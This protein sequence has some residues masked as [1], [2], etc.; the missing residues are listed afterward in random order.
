MGTHLSLSSHTCS[1]T[2]PAERFSTS[3]PPLLWLFIPPPSVKFQILVKLLQAEPVHSI[4]ETG[5]RARI[6]AVCPWVQ[7]FLSPGRFPSSEMGFPGCP[8]IPAR[9]PAEL[10]RQQDE[11]GQPGHCD[12]SEPH[13]VKGRRPSCDHERYIGQSCIERCP[14]GESENTVP[15]VC[16]LLAAHRACPLPSLLSGISSLMSSA[17]IMSPA[18]R[19]QST[20]V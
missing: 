14:G 20:V 2:I 15:S 12:W 13:Q 1:Q 19:S 17:G 6:Q 3:S 5:G 4:P 8:Q 11:C 16:V 7:G 18:Q 9:N 10:C